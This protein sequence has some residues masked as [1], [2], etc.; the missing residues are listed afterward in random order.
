MT[1]T[2]K[3]PTS[4]NLS[5]ER[6]LLLVIGILPIAGLLLYFLVPNQTTQVLFTL[7]VFAA[8]IAILVFAIRR[9]GK[10]NW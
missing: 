8:F 1:K 7:T 6:S 3:K 5:N 9:I 10:K 2:T 4:R